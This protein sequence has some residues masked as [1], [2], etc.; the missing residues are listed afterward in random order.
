MTSL[1]TSLITSL[2]YDLNITTTSTSKNNIGLIKDLIDPND[3]IKKNKVNKQPIF[4][5]LILKYFELYSGSYI[6]LY[7]NDEYSIYILFF[8]IRK[9]ELITEEVIANKKILNIFAM[10]TLITNNIINPIYHQ[11]RQNKFMKD[12]ENNVIEDF[13]FAQ[14]NFI[15]TEL[16]TTQKNNIQ[17]M[18]ER[19]NQNFTIRFSNNIYIN[20]PNNLI[21][22]YTASTKTNT[23]INKFIKISDIPEQSVKGVIICDEPGMGKTLQIITFSIYMY[24]KYN[25]KSLYIYP[26]HLEGHW[27]KQIMIHINDD[28]KYNSVKLSRINLNFNNF[29][30]FFSR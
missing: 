26:D 1:M 15:K 16:W 20:L 2:I 28:I 6:E 8:I 9:P 5:E 11:Y 18:I 12:I 23:S 10:S 25:V 13:N 22:D 4:D 7:D 27:Q 14:P 19:Y 29:K 3:L 17:W 24:K 30:F 21:L